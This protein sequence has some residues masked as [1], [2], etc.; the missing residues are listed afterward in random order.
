M[1]QNRDRGNRPPADIQE[2]V[3]MIIR[4]E[5]TDR[6]RFDLRVVEYIV[7]GGAKA[8]KIERLQFER[9]DRDSDSWTRKKKVGLT[10]ADAQAI[11]DRWPEIK[12]HWLGK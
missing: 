5:E 8:P 1:Y 7:N 12:S 9:E 3:L 10:F 6:Y 4:R 2:N 11:V